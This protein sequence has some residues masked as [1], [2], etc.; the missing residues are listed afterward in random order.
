VTKTTVRNPA[1]T[2]E[3][4]LQAAQHEFAEKGLNGARIDEIAQ[5]SGANKRM[6]YHYL[7]NKEALY[8][9]VLERTY[10]E[11]R[12]AEL[13]LHLENLSPAEGMRKLV[14]FS[15]NYFQEN[16]NFVKM[17]NTENLHHAKYLKKLAN[18][19]KMHSPLIVMLQELLDNGAR[20]GVFR[21]DVDPVQVYISIAALGYFFFSNAPTLSTIFER[22]LLAPAEL[23]TRHDHMVT[24]ILRGLQA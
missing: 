7:G 23:K 20:Q 14:S 4:I 17:L 6:I 9:A 2:K 10:E 5:R 16:P 13:E 24:M 18:I 22:D 1:R 11:I 8:L 3:A 12:S 15:F 21:K 19:Q